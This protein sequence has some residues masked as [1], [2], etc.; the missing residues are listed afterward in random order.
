VSATRLLLRGFSRRCPRCGER[1]IFRRWFQ[2]VDQCP[3]CGYRFNREE[4]SFLGAFVINFGVTQAA[5]G[6]FL[7]IAFAVTLPDP[8]VVRLI[9]IA[10]L[11]VVA[12]PVVFYPFSKTVWTAIDLVMHPELQSN[13]LDRNEATSSSVI[14]SEVTKSPTDPY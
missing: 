10:A 8:P 13:R 14:P 11:V 3:R 1:R 2:M 4:G 6:L 7:V 12:V 5:L 9:V